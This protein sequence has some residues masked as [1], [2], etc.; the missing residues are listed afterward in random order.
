MVDSGG[1]LKSALLSA[2]E[3]FDNE[4]ANLC[5]SLAEKQLQNFVLLQRAFAWG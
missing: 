3:L 5:E 2:K 1:S 4:V